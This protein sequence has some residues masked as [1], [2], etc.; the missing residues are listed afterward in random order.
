MEW[1]HVLEGMTAAGGDSWVLQP[2]Y[3]MAVRRRAPS[4][5]QEAWE[6]LSEIKQLKVI[7]LN[8]Y[9]LHFHTQKIQVQENLL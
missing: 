6:E 4:R 3:D 1:N 8:A 5:I 2:P 7:D 9:D